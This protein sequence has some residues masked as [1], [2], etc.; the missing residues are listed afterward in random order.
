VP[1][2]NQVLVTRVTSKRSIAPP[3]M[4]NYTAVGHGCTLQ[5]MLHHMR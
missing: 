1:I 2:P 4:G 5:P 3:T